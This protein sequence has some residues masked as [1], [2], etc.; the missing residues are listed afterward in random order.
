MWTGRESGPG[1][2][3]AE[4]MASGHIGVIP[5]HFRR[6][7][8]GESVSGMDEAEL[9]RRF[10]IRRDSAALEA[11]VVRYGPMVFGVC[12]RVL[13]NKHDTDDA[14]QATFLVLAKRAGSIRDPAR[15]GAWLHGVAHR[16]AVRARMDAARRKVREG[17]GA[18]EVAVATSSNDGSYDRSELRTTLDEEI[19][20]LPEKFRAPVILC[21]LDGLT[22]DEAAMRLRCPVGTVRS[23]L[24]TG[25]AKLRERLARRGVAVPAGVFAAA[26]TSEVASAA[27]PSILV[28][29]TVRAAIAFAV[30]GAGTTAA[31][32][33]S[34]GA[35]SLAEGVT[36]TMMLTK[37]KIAGGLALLGLLTL[38]IGGAAAQRLGSGGP[39]G[40]T[41]AASA[42]GGAVAADDDTIDD[43]VSK[44]RNEAKLADRERERLSRALS[45]SQKEL[46]RLREQL[47]S[48]GE[49]RDARS[50]GPAPAGGPGAGVRKG[51]RGAAG[52]EGIGGMM[53]SG[54]APGMMGGGGGLGA[55]PQ[56]GG[57][58]GPGFGARGGGLASGGPSGSGAMSG[59]RGSGGGLGMGPAM[60]GGMMSGSG[61]AAG[62][63][64]MGMMG[65]MME[66]AMGGM[67]SGPL[68]LASVQNDEL[69][70]V[71]KPKSD[72]VAAYSTE[73][74]EW[75]A[76]GVPKETDVTPIVGNNIVALQEGGK[77]IG[78]AVAFVPKVGK[79]YPVELKAPAKDGLTPIVGNGVALYPVGRHI[80]AF[81][82]QARGWDV[83]ELEEGAA[84]TP[85]VWSNRATVEHNDHLYIFNLKTGKWTDFDTKTGN[86]VSPN[87]H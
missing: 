62:A 5:S 32:I 3:G 78:E 43:L 2:K 65:G 50:G 23:R 40:A 21:Y 11:L 67:S 19:R 63:P 25:R 85:V 83:L 12:Q 39:A 45:D 18:E 9:L 7:F 22:H 80:Y 44:L 61:M 52:R 68:S 55:G 38:G 66:G 56:G 86:I 72:K 41:A 35:V 8:G 57:G 36:T 84:P 29:S 79:W 77:N 34:G 75:T 82:A 26:L 60:G 48:L 28:D 59:G 58:F 37:I 20:R 74:G 33:V 47:Q 70:V 31:G 13:G 24:S 10:A 81:S 42:G 6:I 15:L 17:P 87:S 14:F 76:Y 30:S 46:E 49:S 71:H 1:E 64:M 4:T 16:I 53:G 54:G 69:I 73:T 27:V 51:A